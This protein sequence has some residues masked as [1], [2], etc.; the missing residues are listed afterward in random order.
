MLRILTVDDNPTNLALT[1]RML[2]RPGYAV[3]TATNP[4]E[5]VAMA[6]RWRY[7]L[8][9][10][11]MSMPGIGGGEA[12]LQIRRAEKAAGTRRRA[13]NRRP[14]DHSGGR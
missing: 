8:I 10:M 3:D 9:V 12:T 4:E 1:S 14:A 11:D 5:G 6:E 13:L 7:D 2:Q